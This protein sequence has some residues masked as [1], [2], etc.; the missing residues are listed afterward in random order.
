MRER[1]SFTDRLWRAAVA[2]LALAFS[3]QLAAAWLA[4][5]LPLLFVLG[6]LT[7]AG[8]LL[9]RRRASRRPWGGSPW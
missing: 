4:A 3:V 1:D 7:S 8:W 5:A 6:G 2:L 9:W